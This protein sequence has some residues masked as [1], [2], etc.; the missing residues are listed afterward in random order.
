MN[1][2]PAAPSRW[3]PI[4]AIWGAI[5]LF[6]A[7]QVVV[8]MRAAGMHHAWSALFV[9]R[10]ALWL[11]WALA[12]PTIMDFVVRHPLWLRG[13]AALAG[14]ARHL[15]LW[16]VIGLAAAVWDAVLESALNPWNPMQA[17]VPVA[18]LFVAKLHDELL[19]SLILYTCIAM[20]G[21]ML[22][23][24]ERLARERIESAQLATALA[25]AQ[26]DAL[27]H[28]VEP[29]FLFNALNAVSGLVREGR[30]DEAVQ[31]LA[32]ISDF[33]RR[34]LQE[35]GVQ[36]VPLAEELALAGTYLDIQRV[37]FADRLQVRVEVA[38]GLGAALVPPLILQPLVENAIKHGIAQRARAGTIAIGAE[39]ADER[40]VLSVYNDGPPL[41]PPAT[42][43]PAD[44]GGSI[45]LA[46]VRERL[47]GLHG[48]AASLDI[49]DVEARG[50]LVSIVIPWREAACPT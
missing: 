6:D 41:A 11:P 8:S 42:P 7:T 48:A 28:Q 37:R 22:D 32:R 49:C 50:V 23:S 39:R 46:N 34:L 40:L 35:R 18:D 16:L 30:G 9:F 17:P 14:L 38:P 15:A 24:R 1:A 19:S 31:T 12:T 2:V 26:L 43:R 5:A 45:G 33:L 21:A 4:A 47:R 27:R 44:G 3:F 20:A 10:L 36:E 29:H 13:P 25:K